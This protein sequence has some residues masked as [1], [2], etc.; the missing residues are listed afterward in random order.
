MELPVMERQGLSK[1]HLRP[2]AKRDP[3]KNREIE[4]QPLHSMLRARSLAIVGASEQ[5][6]YTTTILRCL[7]KSGFDGKIYAVNPKYGSVSGIQCFPD[8]SA[9]P[10]PVD[11]AIVIVPA[12]AVLPA[13]ENAA[14]GCVK[15]ATVYAAGVGEGNEAVAH[16]RGN[17]LLELCAKT[18][19]V[20]AGPNCMGANS[21]W[22]KL[23]LYPNPTLT[24]SAP[25]SVAGVFQSGG[26][27]QIWAKAAID[28]GVRF[29]YAISI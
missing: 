5:S 23:F 8:L 6:Q 11:H 27:V 28:R 13:L 19:L 22:T 14:N 18:G 1:G 29:S 4:F 12:P 17:D 2:P 26:T 21:W 10:H 16:K 3:N 9:L 20:V 15:S 25:G 7:Q 24:D